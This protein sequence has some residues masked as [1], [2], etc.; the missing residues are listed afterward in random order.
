MHA[1]HAWICLNNQKSVHSFRS[2]TVE[3]STRLK[4]PVRASTGEPPAAFSTRQSQASRS[5][6]GGSAKRADLRRAYMAV[7][8]P[9]EQ[10]QVEVDAEQLAR[11]YVTKRR[12]NVVENFRQ[13]SVPDKTRKLQPTKQTV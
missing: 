6:C 2:Y 9:D 4:K 3:R 11:S 8:T 10:K 5:V 1:C 7:L 13:L 12:A